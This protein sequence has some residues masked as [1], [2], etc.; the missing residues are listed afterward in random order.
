MPLNRYDIV[1]TT[2]GALSIIDRSVN[3]IMHNPVGPWVEA[4][5]LYV[6]QAQ[7]KQNLLARYGGDTNEAGELYKL[8]EAGELYKSNEGLALEDLDNLSDIDDLVIFDVGLG[9]AANALATL[10]CLKNIE[11]QRR[12][13]LRLIS[14]EKNLDLL[15]FARQHVEAFPH[16]H[17]F[18]DAVDS[19]L[20]NHHWHESSFS[21]ELR[22][23]D[24]LEAIA[25]ETERPHLIFFDPYSP[26][27]N[28]DM[29]STK[30]FE[31]LY[32]TCRQSSEPEPS[33]LYTY[34]LATPIRVAL[35]QAGFFVGQGSATGLKSET[36]QASTSLHAL[37]QPLGKRWLERW[38]KSQS[39]L[40]LGAEPQEKEAI[41]TMILNH[42][43]F[44]M[45]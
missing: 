32:R 7:V 18:T 41:C 12:R 22:H 9:A 35:F 15:I 24:F 1:T 39:P 37:S 43:Q 10:H 34:S 38:S 29:W 25:R 8:D 14:F 36:T 45:P 31:A 11:N 19:L 30:V 3:E 44:R 20:K 21:W 4:N 6:D 13:K 40:P 33:R 27:V 23:G 17:P 42:P 26:K 16:F 28:P 2:A 5:A